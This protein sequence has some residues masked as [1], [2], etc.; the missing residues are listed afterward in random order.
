MFCDKVTFYLCS[1]VN[2]HNRYILYAAA[3]SHANE[4]SLK[5][6]SVNCKAL[7]SLVFGIKLTV[8]DEWYTI[9][10]PYLTDRTEDY[11]LRYPIP[12]CYCC[13][14]CPG[15]TLAWAMDRMRKWFSWPLRSSDLSMWDFWFWDVS[16][17][18]YQ[19]SRAKTLQQLKERL[20][21]ILNNVT[22]HVINCS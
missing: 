20:L 7:V 8:I 17:R 18:L 15:W 14:Q 11:F 4:T 3:N 5:S 13:S 21:K 9:M 22:L 19:N 16:N 2:F 10:F 1:S 12:F 6:P